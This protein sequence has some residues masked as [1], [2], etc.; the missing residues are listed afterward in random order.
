MKDN[1]KKLSDFSKLFASPKR[2]ILLKLICNEPSYYTKI[3]N[4]FKFFV[5]TPIGS[6]EVYKHLK[7]L[8]DYEYISKQGNTYVPTSKGIKA[9]QKI[10][11]IIKEKP[12][13]PKVR[14]EF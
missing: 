3:F 5:G 12:K 1:M 14:I 7:M 4:D 8:M 2:L 9:I 11:E 10:E 13:I 6:S